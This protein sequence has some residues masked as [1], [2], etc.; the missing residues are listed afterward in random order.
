MISWLSET[1]SSACDA[2]TRSELHAVVST[3]IDALGF[4]SFNLAVLKADKREFMTEPTLTS[5]TWDELSHYD[6]NQW[7]LRDPLLERAAYGTEPLIW[8]ASQWDGQPEHADYSSFIKA[9]GL[10]AGVTVPLLCNK[11][12]LSALTA[13]SFTRDSFSEPTAHALK[14]LGEVV[15]EKT[16]SLGITRTPS[17]ADIN[18]LRSLSD[19]QMTILEWARQGKSNAD[20]AVITNRSKRSVDY[21]MSE[22][23]R[24]LSV[25]SRA[26]AISIYCGR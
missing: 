7:Y 1:V 2:T 21:H 10:R 4:S 26:Q 3:A 25:S 13:L 15:A 17:Q 9:L 14:I 11:P 22:I 20:I 6:A 23:L 16:C 8:T 18:A 5:W 19:Q 12:E 24:R